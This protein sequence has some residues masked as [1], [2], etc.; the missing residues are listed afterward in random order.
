M[1]FLNRV[2]D[3][4]KDFT[5]ILTHKNTICNE[6]R[7]VKAKYIELG[8]LYMQR[9]GED[10][11][12]EFENIVLAI[13]ELEANTESHE[14]EI[15]KLRG[16]VKCTSCGSTVP[17]GAAFCSSCG[18]EVKKPEEKSNEVISCTSC[19]TPLKEN[20]KFCTKCG[21]PA[22]K[23]AKVCPNCNSVPEDGCLYC[24]KC[25]TKL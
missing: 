18:A 23:T 20:D 24:T 15:E 16:I 10:F 1:S 12:P 14:R 6:K 3:K 13:K 19:G 7:A 17:R 21:T 2:T 4:I 8:R 5:G 11:E 25:G 22:E 9:H